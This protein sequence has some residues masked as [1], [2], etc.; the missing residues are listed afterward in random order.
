MTYSGAGQPLCGS[1]SLLG[2]H[3]PA[4]PASPIRARTD[5]PGPPSAETGQEVSPA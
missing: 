1:L 4:D 5:V 2:A 3:Y